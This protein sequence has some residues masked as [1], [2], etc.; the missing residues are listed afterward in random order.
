MRL[1]KEMQPYNFFDFEQKMRMFENILN[2]ATTQRKVLDEML[3]KERH[4]LEKT[5][6]PMK[7]VS[8]IAVDDDRIAVL[9]ERRRVIRAYSREGAFLS[10]YLYTGETHFQDV[11]LIPQGVV[12]SSFF[13][14]HL[15]Y[16]YREDLT[17]P[18]PIVENPRYWPESN[19]RSGAFSDVHFV[20]GE[21]VAVDLLDHSIYVVDLQSIAVSR[22][23]KE[24]HPWW[25]KT[26]KPSGTNEN[27]NPHYTGEILA[28]S[29]AV[30]K[31]EVYI[32]WI[33]RTLE[34][35]VAKPGDGYME[36]AVG[37]LTDKDWR[38]VI[39]LEDHELF[40]GCRH[41]SLVGE[42]IF[43]LTMQGHVY[44]IELADR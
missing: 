29:S 18:V 7:N 22:I 20:D 31:G 35:G 33:D 4:E 30:E 1:F 23:D 9:C 37:K 42:S 13:D 41:L 15:L 16:F 40:G 38:T 21:V 12:A 3:D 36:L 17:K 5:V 2:I 32:L 14:D 19:P 27:L 44:A 28:V 43:F 39:R 11:A 26:E 6:T 34:R 24:P 25:R 10:E 8:E